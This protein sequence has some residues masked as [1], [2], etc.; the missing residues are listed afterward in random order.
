VNR[1]WPFY[2]SPPEAT[3]RSQAHLLLSEVDDQ[4]SLNEQLHW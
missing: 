2:L 3:I 1:F 4:K